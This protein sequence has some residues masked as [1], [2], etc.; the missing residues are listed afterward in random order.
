MAAADSTPLDGQEREALEAWWDRRRIDEN[1]S[2]RECFLD[3]FRAALTVR[4]EAQGVTDEMVER[5]MEALLEHLP[6]GDEERH[7][8]RGR[9]RVKARIVLEAVL[10]GGSYSADPTVPESEL[11]E[12]K[13]RIEELAQ[14]RDA[15]I[16]NSDAGRDGLAI[17]EENRK[18]LYEALD[19]LERCI[20][21]GHRIL[22]H[23]VIKVLLRRHGRLTE[24]ER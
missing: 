7:R 4:E 23:D 8:L 12:A 14:E 10:V 6:G 21:P 11:L 22:P 3:G 24:G 5:G 19:L 16:L 2:P 13:E 17:L 9:A 20:K 15:W 18:E 1:V